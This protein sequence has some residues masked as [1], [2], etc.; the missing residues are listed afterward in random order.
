MI[1]THLMGGL[2]NQLFQLF[3][4][5]AVSL[6]TN[7]RFVILSKYLT[8]FNGGRS[9]RPTYWNNILSG[10]CRHIMFATTL[11]DIYI[12]REPIFAH[13][14][15]PTAPIL[16]GRNVMI[17]GYYQSEK[18]FKDQFETIYDMCR[19]QDMREVVMEKQSLSSQQMENTISM[20]FRIGDYKK[21]THIHPIMTFEYYR[22]ALGHILSAL[23]TRDILT[24]Y[25][26]CEEEDVN[27][28]IQVI[29]KLKEEFETVVFIRASPSL[30]D[31]EQL[32]F[33]SC[34]SNHIIANSSFSWWG[35]YLNRNPTK[36]V[37]YP[38]LWFGSHAKH[39]TMDLAPEEWVRILV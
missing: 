14:P 7:T 23:N 37:C 8:N 22:N 17:Q 24:V 9:D 2:G 11:K 27:I 15:I 31:W 38:S 16:E 3:C 36:I 28:V 1:T 12:I 4:A 10:L 34:C 13:V 26:F 25:Y 20:H 6:R 29:D 19:F 35:A 18:Y 30:Q 33:M 21:L 39:N 5:L 32:L